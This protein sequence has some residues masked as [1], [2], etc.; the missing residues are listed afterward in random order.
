MAEFYPLNVT[1]I[2][3]ETR[4]SVVVTL[5]PRL[6]DAALFRY[7]QG[8]YLTF[9]KAFDGE[10]LR[11][12]YS[13]CSSV[14]DNTLKVGIKKVNGGWFSTWANEELAVGDVLEAMPP[15]GQF[16][17]DLSADKPKNYLL[18]AVGSGIT[19]ILSLAK[20][21]LETEPAS[22]I[23]LTYVNRSFNTIMFREALSDLK[24]RFMTRF[25]VLHMLKH[26]A[27]DI[28]LLTGRID[29]DK[30]DQLF[31]RW[32]SPKHADWAFICGPKEVM[33]MISERLQAHGMDKAQI[34]FELFASAPPK[35]AR[36]KTEINAAKNDVV[37]TVIQDG[38][39]RRIEM[40]RHSG[41]TVLEAALEANIELPYAC[42]AG[43]CSTCM[44]QVKSG[45]VEMQSNYALEDYEVQRGVVLS[46]QSI[47][48]TDELTLSF[49]DMTHGADDR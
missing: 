41:Q 12:S 32:M 43:V 38:Q 9:K 39:T 11:R 35:K 8:Q 17:T 49:D 13:I 47:P 42:Q 34:K 20:T 23:I 19:P 2:R 30:C 45:E 1:N 46:C 10:E 28:D 5:K 27:G 3:R 22:R 6:E 14:N 18:L 44:C 26:D 25:S 4:E 40:S 33:F 7:K 15:M 36:A 16:N 29:A 48:I 37:V 24:D 31:T 21:I